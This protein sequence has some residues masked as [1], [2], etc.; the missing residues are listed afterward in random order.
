MRTLKTCFVLIIVLVAMVVQPAQAQLET[1]AFFLLGQAANDARQAPVAYDTLGL[2]PIY[3]VYQGDNMIG[4][5]PDAK[6][7][8]AASSHGC[9][10]V[11][12]PGNIGRVDI[13]GFEMSSNDANLPSMGVYADPDEIERY[14]GYIGA[15]KLKDEI[16]IDPEHVTLAKGDPRFI[17]WQIPIDTTDLPQGLYQATVRVWYT[18]RRG[19]GL[20]KLRRETIVQ[21]EETLV[22]FFVLDREYMQKAIND[23]NIQR[24][25]M[26]SAGLAGGPVQISAARYT[27]DPAVK[28][29]LETPPSLPVS[30]NV[31]QPAA[32]SN[33]APSEERRSERRV[34]TKIDKEPYREAI[35]AAPVPMT[36]VIRAGSKVYKIKT[37]L[38]AVYS[39]NTL[40]FR[41]GDDKLGEAKVTSCINDN[42]FATMTDG[43]IAFFRRG[44]SVEPKPGKGGK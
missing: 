21:R 13:V 41:R 7:I 20:F 8:V 17:K 4:A 37:T 15:S 22:K 9:T 33:M 25:L 6:T 5:C 3:N 39:G 16:R 38:G 1:A 42:I 26:A 19:T 2:N 34:E 18:Q 43:N 35:G 24:A 27:V 29:Q 44:D 30:A 11:F 36:I 40:V 32:P 23:V 28:R 10:L 12:E 14:K 31:G